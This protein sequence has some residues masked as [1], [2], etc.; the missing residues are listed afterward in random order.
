[1][2]AIQVRALS[3]PPPLQR[4]IMNAQNKEEHQ[5]EWEQDRYEDDCLREDEKYLERVDEHII[6]QAD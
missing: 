1:M 3:E 5:L 2:V 4:R 6:R